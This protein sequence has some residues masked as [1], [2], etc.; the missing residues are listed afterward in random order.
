VDTYGRIIATLEDYR[1]AYVGFVPGLTSLYQPKVADNVLSVVRV[2]EQAIAEKRVK[3]QQQNG[4]NDAFD[5]LDTIEMSYDQI[6]AALG[7]GSR[8]AVTDRI[9]KAITAGLIEITNP[10]AARSVRR[11]YRVLVSSQDVKANSGNYSA[12]PT[13]ERV[14]ELLSAVD[15]APREYPF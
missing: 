9:R 5:S 13:P 1:W 15:A 3:S 8:Q 14:V 10:T 6:V 2:I 4:W 7:L 12:M 11:S